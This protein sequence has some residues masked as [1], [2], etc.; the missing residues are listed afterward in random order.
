MVD[1]E[2]SEGVKSSLSHQKYILASQSVT[3]KHYKSSVD[4]IV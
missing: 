4:L 1:K 3:S 2:V